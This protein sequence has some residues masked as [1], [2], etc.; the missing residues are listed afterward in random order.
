MDIRFS[1]VDIK[2]EV[3][4]QRFEIVDLKFYVMGIRLEVLE[5]KFKVVDIRLYVIYT[6]RRWLSLPK[7]DKT[8]YALKLAESTFLTLGSFLTLLTTTFY[9]PQVEVISD[10]PLSIVD[11]CCPERIGVYVSTQP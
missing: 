3:V 8:N 7:H 10:P 2:F 11:F 6:L 5:I 4:D 9:S 1:V